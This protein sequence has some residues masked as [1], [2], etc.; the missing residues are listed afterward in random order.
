MSGSVGSAEK[1]RAG[2]AAVHVAKILL[3]VAVGIAGVGLLVT[4]IPE[5][6]QGPNG[7]PPDS[8]GALQEALRANTVSPYRWL[9]LAEGYEQAAEIEKARW[10]FH[11]AEEFGPNLP[12]VWIRAATFHL[13]LGEREA[14]VRA[15]SHAQSLSDASDEFLFAYYDR[16]V[17]DTPLVIRILADNQRSLTA[18]LRHLMAINKADEAERTWTE[19]ERQGFSDPKLGIAYVEFL[20]ARRRYKIAEDVWVRNIP[21]N[22][23]GGYPATN[24]IFNGGFEHP[25]SGCRLDWKLTK[26]DSVEMERDHSVA[27]EGD[28]SLRLRFRGTEN[29]SFQNVVQTIVT[30]AGNYRFSAW[31]KTEGITTD[32]GLRFCLVDA[33]SPQKLNVE[34]ESISGTTGWVEV[35][36]ELAVPA[37]TNLLNL[38]VCRLPSLKFEN[39]ISGTAW[40]DAVSMSRISSGF[41]R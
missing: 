19:I 11:Q 27:K 5:A 30:S 26:M 18:Y 15:G 4:A 20:L 23:R 22:V 8:I 3:A 41:T 33:E 16:F 13:R 36:R 28:F 17:E 32:Q 31:V 39:K 21:V 14:G 2:D 38:T 1:R 6:I 10:C 12:P 35:H 24:R 9:E 40:I 34:M 29:V 7:S 37:Q 25:A